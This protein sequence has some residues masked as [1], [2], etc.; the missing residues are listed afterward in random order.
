MQTTPIPAATRERILEV[1]LE[2]FAR[3]G[4]LRTSVRDIA[5]RVGFTKAAVHYHFP[6]KI[7][8][9]LALAEPVWRD[10]ET[11]IN[12][13]ERLP[14]PRWP[15][16]EGW[17]D[18]LLKHRRVFEMIAHDPA[19]IAHEETYSYVFALARRVLALIAGP[20]A[21]LGARVRGA[22]A[23]AVLG[24]PVLYFPEVPDHVLRAEVL[25]GVRCLLADV[26]FGPAGDQVNGHSAAGPLDGGR[27][28]SGEGNTSPPGTGRPDGLRQNRRRPGRPAALTD[29]GRVLARR[30]HGE[31]L[32]AEQIATA[33]G[34]SRATIY[35]YLQL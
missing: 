2:L 14:D 17:L 10:F 13:A 30:M 34:V 21:G 32:A 28:L 11:M 6:R 27:L 29:Q 15:V 5:E 18:V 20:G 12:E 25:A 4:Y 23:M 7:D 31:G 22:Q 16:V 35:R 33:L 3:Q 8:I 9:M 24:D 19:L 1:A 26:P